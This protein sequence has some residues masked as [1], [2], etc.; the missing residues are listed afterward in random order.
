MSDAGPAQHRGCDR[1]LA[2]RLTA[3][4]IVAVAVVMALTTVLGL[5]LLVRD[6]RRDWERRAAEYA[7]DLA[8]AIAEPVAR[9]DHQAVASACGAF[10]LSDV[11]SHLSVLDAGGAPIFAF[12][13]RSARHL[14]AT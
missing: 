5:A 7:E 9:A 1:T 12:G 14:E 11:A 10:A 6:A 8:A 4:L 2:G 3:H 13:E